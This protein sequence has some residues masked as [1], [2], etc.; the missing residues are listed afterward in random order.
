MSWNSIHDVDHIFRTRSRLIPK[1]QPRR[2]S[3]YFGDGVLHR[4]PNC[5]PHR[6]KLVKPREI[7]K[8][9]GILHLLSYFQLKIY[10]AGFFFQDFID[11]LQTFFLARIHKAFFSKRDKTFQALHQSMH[12]TYFLRSSLDTE[13]VCIDI[14]WDWF[15][16][17]A[18]YISRTGTKR[19][20]V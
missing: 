17:Y 14:E 13:N 18:F 11:H 9:F 7:I 20:C 19:D 15:S 1:S 5:Q 12:T 16:I 8:R 10:V 6:D 4:K 2:S 3:Y